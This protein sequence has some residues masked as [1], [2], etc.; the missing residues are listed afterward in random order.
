SYSLE[1]TREG[2]VVIPQVG[3]VFVANLTL[4]QAGD[5]LYR[6]LRSVYSGL[7]REPTS[8]TKIYVTVARLR[9]NQVFVVGDVQTPG[10]YQLSSA[11]TMLTALYAAGGPTDNGNLRNI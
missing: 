10:S 9:A 6:R 7:G 2:F 5:V 1:V 4:E 8:S 3:Q 11:G